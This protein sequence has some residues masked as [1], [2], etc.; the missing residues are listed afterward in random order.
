MKKFFAASIL[1]VF[2]MVSASANAA[3]FV[4]HRHHHH[5]HHHPLADFKHQLKAVPS[6]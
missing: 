3:M 5:H 1:A 4:K 2:A 6:A